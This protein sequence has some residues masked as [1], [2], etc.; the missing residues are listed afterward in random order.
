VQ[1]TVRKLLASLTIALA[2]TAA[3]APAAEVFVGVPPGNPQPG[4]QFTIDVTVDAGAAVLGAYDVVF[5]YDPAVI[6]VVSIAGGTTAE[7]SAAPTTNPAT[8][9]SGVTRF[10]AAHGN[11]ASPTGV[12]TVARL[13][14]AAQLISLGSSDLVLDPVALFDGSASPLD[15]DVFNSSVLTAFDPTVPTTTSSTSTTTSSSTTSTSTTVTTTTSTTTTSAPTTTST[16]ATTT[17]SSSTSSSSSVPTAST[18]ST[19]LPLPAET[20]GNCADDDEDGAVDYE[21]ADCCAAPAAMQV[22]KGRLTGKAGTT[23]GKLKLAAVLAQAGF[24]DVDPT[25]SDVTIQLRNPGGELLCTTVS[26]SLWKKKRKA[27]A[28]RDPSGARAGG[29]TAADV[30]PQ[31]SGIVRFSA[32]G[33]GFDV[34]R[35][36]GPSLGVTVRVGD[37]CSRGTLPLRQTKKGLVGP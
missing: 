26:R 9:A 3:S 29:L 18:T 5:R 6:H 23:G 10:V 14:L 35:F 19:T 12:V 7:F 4:S 34:G 32:A 13:T 2:V 11:T 17:S 1:L 33:K 30:K 15:A 8:F 36:A 27:F 25:Q 28:F 16:S 20:C 37:R 31:K 24:A 21:D 22:S